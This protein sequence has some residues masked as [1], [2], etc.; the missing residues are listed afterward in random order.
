MCRRVVISVD[1]SFNSL[2]S[3]KVQWF[4]HLDS[5]EQ[6][7]LMTNCI[8]ELHVPSSMH[9]RRLRY[10]NLSEN[11]ISEA[12]M[13][14]SLRGLE[15]LDLSFNAIRSTQSLPQ[16]PKLQSLVL[17]GNTLKDTRSFST[18]FPV[19]KRLEGKWSYGAEVKELVLR[20]TQLPCVA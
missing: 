14:E 5:L 12:T 19:L 2:R 13:L 1:A 20:T 6:L 18:K 3:L 17:T 11:R 4:S 9:W 10:L 8:T 15:H 7:N 16:L